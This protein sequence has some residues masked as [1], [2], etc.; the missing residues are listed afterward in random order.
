MVKKY[1]DIVYLSPPLPSAQFV[2]LKNES[3]LVI[4]FI[5]IFC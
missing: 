3:T 5:L 2:S 4:E 1:Y